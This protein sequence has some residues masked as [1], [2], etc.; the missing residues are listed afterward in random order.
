MNLSELLNQGNLT[1]HK[2]SKEEI[3]N[4]LRL[5]KRDIQDAKVKSVSSDRRFATA[6]NAILQSAI[7]VVYC[8]GYKP[9]GV[10]HHS[11]VFKAIREIMGKE[12]YDLVDYFDSCRT[13]RNIT[14]YSHIGGISESEVEE[15]IEEAGKFLEIV[16]NWL[17]ENFPQLL[18][19]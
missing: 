8:R 14:D 13:K 15:L 5:I 12:H 7:M 4:L 6:Y 10:G 16:H 2:T 3:G 18:D 9:K 11:T 19:D 1:R 17:K